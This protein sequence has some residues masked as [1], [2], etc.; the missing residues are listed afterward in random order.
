[1]KNAVEL[2]LAACAA[3]GV[4]WGDDPAPEVIALMEKYGFWNGGLTDLGVDAAAD[5]SGFGGEDPA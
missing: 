1:V 3:L 5:A 4:M 2:D